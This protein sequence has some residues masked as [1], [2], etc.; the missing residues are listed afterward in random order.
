MARLVLARRFVRRC[1]DLTGVSVLIRV[2]AEELE[3]KSRP[4]CSF[5]RLISR[6]LAYW[7]ASWSR[8]SYSLLSWR[9][10][11]MASSLAIVED[12]IWRDSGVSDSVY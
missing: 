6:E 7:A 1:P 11:I 10:W 4:S 2:D 5:R 12:S 3:T 9:F 8:H